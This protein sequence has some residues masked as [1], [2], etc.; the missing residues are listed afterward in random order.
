[1]CVF[2][3]PVHPGAPTGPINPC[4]PVTPLNPCIPLSPLIPATWILVTSVKSV[5][6]IT[7]S[8]YT[9]NCYID[10]FINLIYLYHLI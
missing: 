9:S 8:S 6:V 10:V 5:T 1:L 3:A 2:R 7:I 4:N